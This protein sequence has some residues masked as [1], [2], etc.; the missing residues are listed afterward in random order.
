MNAVIG[1]TSVPAE[2]CAK[3]ARY[4]TPDLVRQTLIDMI[5]IRSPTGSEAGMADYVIDRL[6]RAGLDASRQ[7]VE[8]DRPNAVGHLPGRGDGLNLLFTGGNTGKVIV[9]V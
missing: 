2:E 1:K 7:L 4:I 9:K 6:R 5:D 3:A 8:D